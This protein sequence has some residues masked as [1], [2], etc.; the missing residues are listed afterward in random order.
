MLRDVVEKLAPLD[1]TPCS[2]GEREA[3]E[4]L[5]T[6]LRSVAGVD[7]ALEDE[8]SWGIFPPT[9]VGLGT[10]G[11][12]AALL[13]MSGRRGGA[14]LA[15]AGLAGIVD[16]AQ[17]GPRVVRRLVRRRRQTVNLVAR[18]ECGG[19]QVR[20]NGAAENGAAERGATAKAPA[21]LVV[22]AH[23]DAPQSGLLF[24]Q[25]LQRRLHA[26][27]P[28]L[29]GRTKTPPPQWWIGLAGPLF[30]IAGAL[31]AARAWPAWGW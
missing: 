30:T 10:L 7:V 19:V 4:W 29:M 13:V 6:R 12:A 14:L 22:L 17:N 9:A 23:H 21:T 8:P 18:V 16:E 28:K 15:A 11:L 27:A 31:P 5:A 24:D 1:R 26:L 25:T 3:A 2:A 20:D